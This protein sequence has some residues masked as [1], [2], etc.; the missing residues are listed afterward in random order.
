MTLTDLVDVLKIVNIN[1]LICSQTLNVLS[2]TYALF[3]HDDSSEKI[4]LKL[5]S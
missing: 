2:N 4:I 3:W 5:K 1:N